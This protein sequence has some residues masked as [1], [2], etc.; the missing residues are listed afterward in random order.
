MHI[1]QTWLSKTTYPGLNRTSKWF[2]KPNKPLPKDG[3]NLTTGILETNL[4][5]TSQTNCSELYYN[6][7]RMYKGAWVILWQSTGQSDPMVKSTTCQI[8]F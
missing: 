8:T 2:I 5:T 4:T 1:L 6:D 7:V 3:V